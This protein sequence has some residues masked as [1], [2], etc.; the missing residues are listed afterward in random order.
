VRDAEGLRDLFAPFGPVTVRRM[1]GGAGV[2]ADGLC[3]A[4]A[5]G[6]GE[7]YIKVDAETQGEFAAAGSQAFVYEMQGK[8]K[9]MA[10]WRLVAEAYDDEDALKRWARL[11]LDAARRAAAVKAAKAA[12]PKAKRTRKS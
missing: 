8:P 4:I 9:S 1:F 10:F 11:G 12:R 6:S 5:P 3:F 2:Y 7:V